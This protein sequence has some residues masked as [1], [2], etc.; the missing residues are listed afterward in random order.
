MLPRDAALDQH[1]RLWSTNMVQ[2]LRDV[3]GAPIAGGHHATGPPGL[4]LVP[5]GAES[6]AALDKAGSDVCRWGSGM[7][8]SIPQGLTVGVRVHADHSALQFQGWLRRSPP[9]SGSKPHVRRSRGS[10]EMERAGPAL[11]TPPRDQ[12]QLFSWKQGRFN[13]R[14]PRSR[15]LVTWATPR[16]LTA[17]YPF[18]FLI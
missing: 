10:L 15:S 9:T 4:L 16:S 18:F 17:K 12:R 7:K 11:K 13:H 1:T 2:A 3:G 6:L 5:E 14:G 8:K